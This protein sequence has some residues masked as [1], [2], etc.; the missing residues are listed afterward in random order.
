[1]V[2][3][4]RYQ[5]SIYSADKKHLVIITRDIITVIKTTTT[6]PTVIME[7]RFAPEGFKYAYHVQI[8]PDN[9]EVVVAVAAIDQPQMGMRYFAI[10]RIENNDLK[11]Q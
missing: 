3:S 5:E 1:M 8:T 7:D 9:T 2:F 10:T 6:S 11:T 4:G